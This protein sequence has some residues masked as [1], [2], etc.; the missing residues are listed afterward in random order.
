MNDIVDLNT[1]FNSFSEHWQPRLV[2]QLNGQHVKVAKVLG[3]FDWHHHDNEDELFLVHKG[4]LKIELRDQSTAERTVVL[5][6]GQFFVVP[7]GVQ[8]RP[9]AENEVHLVLF[10]PAGTLNTGNIENERTVHDVEWLKTNKNSN[11]ES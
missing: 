10:E 4:Q 1:V 7:R 5:N 8:H 11:L 6:P 9:V 2:A 3:E